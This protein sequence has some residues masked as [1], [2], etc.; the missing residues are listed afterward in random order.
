MLQQDDHMACRD[1]PVQ[2][3][4]RIRTH[5]DVNKSWHRVD[6]VESVRWSGGLC[7]VTES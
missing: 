2:I 5:A 4:T 3:D 7:R 1:L 6:T